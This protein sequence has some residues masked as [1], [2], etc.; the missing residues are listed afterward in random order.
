MLRKKASSLSCSHHVSLRRRIT[1]R[2]LG[3]CQ[4]PWAAAH[5][6]THTHTEPNWHKTSSRTDEFSIFIYSSLFFNSLSPS[7]FSLCQS[8]SVVSLSLSHADGL[9]AGFPGEKKN[10][11]VTIKLTQ[12]LGPTM[13]SGK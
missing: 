3:C 9:C 2:R 7:I 5:T 10:T 8:L 4:N 6:Q 11:N 12:L 1:S 13:R